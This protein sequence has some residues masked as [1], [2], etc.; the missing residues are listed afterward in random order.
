[1]ARHADDRAIL[2]MDTQA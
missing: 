2:E 1:V